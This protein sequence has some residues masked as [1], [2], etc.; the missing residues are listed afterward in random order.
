MADIADRANEQADYLLQVALGRR[1]IPSQQPSA[2]FC[3]DCGVVIPLLRRQAVS[4]CETCV[5][6]QDRRERRR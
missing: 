4:G 2:E 3:M 1:A 6:C 5:F